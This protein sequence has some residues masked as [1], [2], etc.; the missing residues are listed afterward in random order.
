MLLNNFPIVMLRC[1]L[2]TVV[3]ECAVAYILG[4]RNRRD[5]LTVMLAN[6]M[7]NP[8]LVAVTTTV[9]LF[10]GRTPYIITLLLME[11]AAVISEA[12]VYRRVMKMGCGANGKKFAI[13]RGGDVRAAKKWAP[14]ALS[15]F[16]NCC[17]YFG[18]EI[19]N[20]LIY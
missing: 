7:T 10:W 11:I 12:F 20:R 14:I 9:A 17:S 2:C 6:T 16:L 13:F 3:M 19:I 1:L 4:I 8:I 15:L 5:L 18:G